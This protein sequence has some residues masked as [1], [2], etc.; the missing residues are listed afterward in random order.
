[1]AELGVGGHSSRRQRPSHSLSEVEASATPL[2]STSQPR[3]QFPRQRADGSFHL[4]KLQCGCVHQVD[5]FDHRLSQ[6]SGDSLAAPVGHQTT[7]DLLLYL[8]A[9]FFE[10]GSHILAEQSSLEVAEIA[11]GAESF[12][13]LGFQS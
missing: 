9:Q 4:G 8:F 6:R 2:S 1:M 3:G 12:H 5:I 13:Q 11:I 10:S 7:P